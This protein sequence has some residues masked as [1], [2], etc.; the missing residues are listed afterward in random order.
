MDSEL[1]YRKTEAGAAEIIGRSL[2]LT[3]AERRL[4]ILIDGA[5]SVNDLRP[6][7]RQGDLKEALARLIA[8]GLI[9]NTA[10]TGVEVQQTEEESAKDRKVLL[11]LKSELNGL[12]TTVLGQRGVVLDAR[13][14]DA[15]SLPVL[16][17]VVRQ[18][19]TEARQR[20]DEETSR[21]MD[22]WIGRVL[23]RAE[24]AGASL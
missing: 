21:Q 22:D 19:L 14:Q 12:F 9:V 23:E 13:V 20:T 24:R 6:F 16:R 8:M 1:V 11:L 4:L 15:V 7:V 18:M 2:E 10:G 17:T 3:P 5:R